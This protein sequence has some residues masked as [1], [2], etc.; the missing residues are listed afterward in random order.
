[1]KN[2]VSNIVE[3]RV[4]LLFVAAALLQ[5]L[6]ISVNMLR[7]TLSQGAALMLNFIVLS[8][9]FPV[10]YTVDPQ[11]SFVKKAAIAL[12]TCAV[13]IANDDMVRYMGS[14]PDAAHVFIKNVIVFTAFALVVTL[15]FS[16]DSKDSEM[17]RIARVTGIVAALALV[18]YAIN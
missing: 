11:R 13:F 6:G 17:V 10:V 8:T 1:M 7:P 4:V 9:F 2:L 14:H 3:T 18:G 12:G 15:M 16:A 5:G